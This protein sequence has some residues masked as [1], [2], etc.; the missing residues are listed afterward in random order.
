[1]PHKNDKYVVYMNVSQANIVSFCIY[2][3]LLVSYHYNFYTITKFFDMHHTIFSQSTFV[4]EQKERRNNE[5]KKKELERKMK[6]V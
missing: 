3:L 5:R 6:E 2:W 4:C 1:M